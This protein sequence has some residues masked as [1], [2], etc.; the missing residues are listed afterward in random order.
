M[1]E[2]ENRKLFSATDGWVLAALTGLCFCVYLLTAS[3]TFVSGS[4]P[5]G[6]GALYTSAPGGDPT[7]SGPSGDG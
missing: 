6:S 3:F 5:D 7:R 2:M 4:W 1:A